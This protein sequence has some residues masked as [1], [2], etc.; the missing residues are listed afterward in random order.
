MSAIREGRERIRVTEIECKTALSPSRLPGFDYTLNP[1]RGCEHGCKYCY[2]PNILRIPRKEWGEFVEVRRN[3]PKVLANE[4]KNKKRGVVGIST[5]TD[6]YQPLERSFKLTHYCLKQL[7]RFDFPVSI[8]TK[9]PLVTRDVDLLSK[10]SEAEVGFTITTYDD[11]ERRLLEPNTSSI[12]SRIAALEKCSKNGI[13]TYAFLG[14]LYPTIDEDRLK[15]LVEKVKDAGASKIM[16]DRLNLKPGVWKSVYN[17][18]GKDNTIGNTWKEAVFG[19]NEGYPMLFNFL[20]KTCREKGI[21]FEMEG[22]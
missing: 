19:E 16:A 14:P 1:Y 5:V 2:A 13:I 12:K 21:E 9:S 3:I 20:K 4:L 7:L 18:L 17:S 22:Y 11:S 8:I 6:P 15:K 10:F